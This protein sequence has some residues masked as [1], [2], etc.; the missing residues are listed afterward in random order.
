MTRLVHTTPDLIERMAYRTGHTIEM[1]AD[2]AFLTVGSTT[3][4]A[5]LPAVTQ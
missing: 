2:A 4:V 5:P 1:T 3:W